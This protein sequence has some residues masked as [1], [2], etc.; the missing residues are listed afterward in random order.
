MKQETVKVTTLTSDPNNVRKHSTRNIEAVKAS[1]TKFGQQKPIVVMGDGTVIAGNATLEAARL[2]GWESIVIV[3][4]TL[5]G[6]EATAFAIADNR[7]AEMAM[8][9]ADALSLV[10]QELDLS[11]FFNAGEIDALLGKWDLTNTEVDAIEAVKGTTG[12]MASLKVKCK[13]DDLDDIRKTVADAIEKY[14]G[15]SVV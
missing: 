2:L 9:D 15:A 11:A 8:W 10:A 3:R 6:E 7:T 12:A 4:T 1:L 5:M 13:T 14:D